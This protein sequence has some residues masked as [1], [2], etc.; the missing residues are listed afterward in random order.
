VSNYLRCSKEYAQE[1]ICE[2]TKITPAREPAM[3]MSDR[4]AFDQDL[5]LNKMIA[6]GATAYMF[7]VEVIKNAR[8]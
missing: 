8:T 4:F 7:Y 3:L 6:K 1:R 5:V 2:T